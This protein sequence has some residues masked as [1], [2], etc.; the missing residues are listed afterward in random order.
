MKLLLP[1]FV[2]LVN[3][4][5]PAAAF[6]QVQ[7]TVAAQT[8]A[9]L[10]L[11]KLDASEF[12]Q[13]WELA[14]SVFKSALTRDAWVKAAQSARKPLGA[15]KSRT[16]KSVTWSRSLPGVPDGQYVVIQYD[17]VF[18][19]K[20]GSVETLTVMVDTDDEWRMIGYFIK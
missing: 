20:A 18:E 1:V 4:L 17:T 16:D 19:N 12:E 14:A 10:W 5:M 3:C 11:E 7:N 2:V 15:V 6:A 9:S 8:A 13:T